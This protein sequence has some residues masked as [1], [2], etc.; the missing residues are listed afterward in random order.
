MKNRYLLGAGVALAVAF[1]G[2]EA[3][4]QLSFLGGPYPVAYYI[5]PEGGW[6]SLANQKDSITTPP[7][8]VGDTNPGPF[9]NSFNANAR[10]DSGYNV[11]ARAGIRYRETASRSPPGTL[12]S[13]LEKV[14]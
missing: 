13:R 6:T 5:G 14:V 1:G 8:R 10:Y 12:K 3:N 7:F 11:G 2:A 9:F 4:A